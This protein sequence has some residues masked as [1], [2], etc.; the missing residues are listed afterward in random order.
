MRAKSLLLLLIAL[1]CGIV[2][3]VAVSQ[4][5]LDQNGGVAVQTAEILVIAK[6]V[7]AASKIT[8]ESVRIEKWPADKVPQ[9]ALVDLKQIEGKFA[10]QPL[11]VNEPLIEIKLANKGK[12]LVIPEGY[13]VFDLV[14]NEQNGG[15][16]YIS[17]GDRV[18]VFGFFEK[19][20]K[21]KTSGTVRVLENLEVLMVDGIASIDP[22][23][24]TTA[25]RSSSTFQLLVKDKQ[26]A[27]LDTAANLGKLRVAL[28]PPELS[29]EAKSR[30]D[31]GES[32]MAW[33][34]E[35]EA[36]RSSEPNAASLVREVIEQ[37]AAPK[38]EHEMMI[39]TPEG[40]NRF[41]WKEGDKMPRKVDEGAETGIEGIST[42]GIQ[43]GTPSASGFA[44]PPAS[45][46][47]KEVA[48]SG[49]T[50]GSERPNLNWDPNGGS[51]QLGG[52]KAAYPPSK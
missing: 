3:S 52:F 41:R 12:E 33:L 15:S 9:G 51:W 14:V 38:I 37:P 17:P 45:G 25:R 30:M 18:D 24:P 48:D 28:R 26:Y 13:R 5:V 4:V 44:P 21:I 35:S 22:D 1:G 42:S 2:A 16:G 7:S 39:I 20:M 36:P 43:S 32:F 11:Y 23:A 19:G 29:E 40:S 46:G 50:K 47:S 10:K 31:D 34:K 8:P 6:N 49:S 27:V